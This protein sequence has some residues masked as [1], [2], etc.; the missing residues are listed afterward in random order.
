M[1]DNKTCAFLGLP[2]YFK[3][4]SYIYPPKVKD[5]A[6]RDYEKFITILT[7]SNDDVKDLFKG[8]E[9]KEYPSPF[10]LM[11]KN[12]IMDEQLRDLTKRAFEFFLHEP[13]TF[14]VERGIIILGDVEELILKKTPIENI[15]YIDEGNYFQFQNLIRVAIGNEPEIEEKPNPNEDPR[16]TRLKQ[17][18]KEREKILA[19][20]KAK[21]GEVLKFDECLAAICCMGIGL[22]PLNIGE[23][24]YSAISTL[25]KT[26]QRKESYDNLSIGAMFGTIDTK[27]T[28][29]EYWIGNSSN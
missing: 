9:V 28:K 6:H 22:T 23:L 14:V 7:M 26:Y 10:K 29:I 13:V 18:F 12:Y 15:Y 19:K 24:S 17:R 16:V 4:N 3:G 8:T 2:I 27:K 21:K 11:Y 25:M 5:V 20:A 1:I